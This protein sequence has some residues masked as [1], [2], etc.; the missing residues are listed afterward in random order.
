MKAYTRALTILF[1]LISI[2]MSACAVNQREFLVLDTNSIHLGQP[3]DEVKEILGPPDARQKTGPGK[4][5]WYYYH[6]RKHFYQYIPLIGPRLGTN[7][8]EVLQVR[9]F[10]SRVEKVTFYVVQKK[11]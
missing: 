10:S 8:I 3:A 5:A 11:K 1:L 9:F 2:G 4:E 6:P 7:E